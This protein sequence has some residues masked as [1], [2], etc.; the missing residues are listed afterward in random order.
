MPFEIR[1][2]VAKKVVLNELAHRFNSARVVDLVDD[3][4]LL[5]LTE[6]LEREINPDAAFPFEGLR[7]SAGIAGL[8]A[9]ASVSGP[10]S[11]VEA[12]YGG[13]N[14]HQ[15][16]VVYVDGRIDKGPIVDDSVWDPREA[17]LQDR[18]V[19]QALRAVGVVCE[20]ESDEWD[21]AGL[22]RHR[23]TDDWK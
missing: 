20:P 15:A 5:P 2:L 21:A 22:S 14:S 12:E 17:G 6:A 23:C 10:I 1:A 19:D 13:G 4:G 18:P 11:Y 7:L 3:L 9:E 8:A 16:G